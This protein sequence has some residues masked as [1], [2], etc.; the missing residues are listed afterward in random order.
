M[1][2]SAAC[3]ESKQASCQFR[4]RRANDFV[5]EFL[6]AIGVL[7]SPTPFPRETH[8]PRNNLHARRSRPSAPSAAQH[9]PRDDRLPD[10]RGALV[11]PEEPHVAMEPR[12]RV[13]LDRARPATDLHRPVG[14]PGTMARVTS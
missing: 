12:N 9:L 4:R 8:A 14:D 10:L 11:E 3:P 2:Q 13:L 7:R 5:I 1:L 6:N